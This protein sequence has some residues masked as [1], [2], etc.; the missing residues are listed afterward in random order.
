MDKTHF[1]S[2]CK[3]LA[4]LW[5]IYRDESAKY[6]TWKEYFT[7]ADVALPLAFAKHEGIVTGIRE[8]GK[9]YITEAWD[10]FCKMI[11]IDPEANYESVFDAFAAADK[12][13]E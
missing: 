12:T 13:P 9:A 11:D 7:W 10:V 4:E 8:E 2:V 3:V 5:V 1:S 6:Q